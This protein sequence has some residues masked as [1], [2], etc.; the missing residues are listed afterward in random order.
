LAVG[1]LYGGI[2]H[3]CCAVPKPLGGDYTSH[4]RIIA[5]WL[6]L[7]PIGWKVYL[8]ESAV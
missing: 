7:S 1:Y 4:G 5:G 2:A 6:R 8:A 3:Q